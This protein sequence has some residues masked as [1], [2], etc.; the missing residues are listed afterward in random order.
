MWTANGSEQP[1]RQE[2]RKQPARRQRKEPAGANLTGKPAGNKPEPLKP[3]TPKE[4]FSSKYGL[5]LLR[6]AQCQFQAKHAELAASSSPADQLGYLRQ[7]ARM[8]LDWVQCSALGGNK[9]NR[10]YPVLKTLIPESLGEGTQDPPTE[11][12]RRPSL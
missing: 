2:G 9:R 5:S 11:P 1:P 6:D 3:L 12:A 7:V 8:Y 10:A 4:F